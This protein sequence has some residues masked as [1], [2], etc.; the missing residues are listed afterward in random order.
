MKVDLDQTTAP[1]DAEPARAAAGEGGVRMAAVIE[2]ES[3]LVAFGEFTGVGRAVLWVLGQA[4]PDDRFEV[5]QRVAVS[6]EGGERG[7]LFGGVGQEDI[8]GAAAGERQAPR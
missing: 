8:H 1:A 4:R 3:R 5:R 6:A 2:A 7:R